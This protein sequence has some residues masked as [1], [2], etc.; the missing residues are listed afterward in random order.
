[1]KTRLR[2]HLEVGVEEERILS[3]GHYSRESN[4]RANV[5]RGRETRQSVGTTGANSLFY[6]LRMFTARMP[7]L[8]QNGYI[9]KITILAVLE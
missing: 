8:T 9:D 5:S 7:V 4:P 2:A 6:L 1:M 3:D